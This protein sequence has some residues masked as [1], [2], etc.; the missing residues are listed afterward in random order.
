[1]VPLMPPI[2]W[3]GHL[4]DYLFEFGPV[5]TD[6]ALEA[7]DVLA[8]QQVL[9]V[10]FKPWEARL[11]LRLSREYRGEMHVASKPQAKPPWPGAESQWRY[12]Q[13]LRS[14]RN[15]DRFLA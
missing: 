7:A 5:K 4:V 3:A 9:G 12:V 10:K 6:S 15:L 8:I 14:E 2:D 11:L 13:R 1:M